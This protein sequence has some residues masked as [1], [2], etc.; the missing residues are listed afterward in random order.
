MN[1]NN[2]CREQNQHLNS[3]LLWLLAMGVCKIHH[4]WPHEESAIFYFRNN[5]I[6]EERVVQ[7]SEKY[8]DVAGGLN[9]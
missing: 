2:S 3:K 6:V 5:G 4:C 9:V 8:I 1:E 7:V